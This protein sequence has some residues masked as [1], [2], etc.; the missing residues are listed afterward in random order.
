[1]YVYVASY[2]NKSISVQCVFKISVPCVFKM[3]G[4]NDITVKCAT[5]YLRD[6]FV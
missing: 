6:S 5:R 4:L 1:M 3:I 2:Y